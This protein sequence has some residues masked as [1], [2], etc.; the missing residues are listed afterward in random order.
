M[1]KLT[2]SQD[3]SGDFASIS[4]AVLAVPYELEAEICIGPGIYREK[5]VCE[6]HAL[7]L[8]GAGAD[9]TTLIFGDGGKLPHPDGRP[10]HTFRSYTAFFSGGSVTVE[11]L[12]IANDA[13]P[14]SAVGQ[15]IAAYVDAERPCSAG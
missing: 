6:K 11:D 12:T 14:G 5:L 15:A 1:L 7:T 13:G 10:T 8:R 9:A 2:V 4:E 3:G